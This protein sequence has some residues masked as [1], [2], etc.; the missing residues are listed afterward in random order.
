MLRFVVLEAAVV[1]LE[2]NY[3]FVVLVVEVVVVG[4][5]LMFLEYN[6]VFLLTKM[7]LYLEVLGT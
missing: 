6:R 1:V 7:L 5:A 4:Q 2:I 3:R